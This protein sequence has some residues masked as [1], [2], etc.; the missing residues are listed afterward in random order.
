MKNPV[1]L[2]VVL[3]ALALRAYPLHVFYLHPDQELVP[4][5]AIGSLRAGNWRPG[6]LVYPTGLMYTLRAGYEVI[7]EVGH[8]LGYFRD[9]AEFVG[10]WAENA[11]RFQ[12]LGRLW[13]CLLGVITVV[14]V[15]RLSARLFEPRTGLLA[16]LFLAVSFLHVRES[17]YASLDVP[18]T[19]FFTAAL[20]AA[21]LAQERGDLRRATLYGVFVGLA[22]AYRYQA[23]VAAL[24]L[25]VVELLRTPRALGRSALG[26]VAAGVGA[27][28]AFALLSPYT[29]LEPMR[30]YADVAGQAAETY[31]WHLTPSLPLHTLLLAGAGPGMC[32]LAIVGLLA[33]LRRNARASLPILVPGAVYAATLFGAQRLFARYTVLILP[34]LAIFA[35]CGVCALTNLARRPASRFGLGALVLLAVAEPA[36]RSLALDRLLAREDTRLAAARWVA[37]HVPGGEVIGINTTAADYAL[38]PLPGGFGKHAAGY[39]PGTPYRFIFFP[40]QWRTARRLEP[41]YVITTEYPGL[42]MFGLVP[43]ETKILLHARAILLADFVGLREGARAIFD[44]TDANYTPLFGFSWVANPGPNIRIWKLLDEEQRPPSTA[45]P[46]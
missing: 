24:A 40:A 44:P 19:A 3:L 2:A 7:Y 29:L 5:M 16:S 30:A 8:L 14:L 27:L 31:T 39:P 33:A 42:P 17:H 12:L 25:P 35:A 1:A 37:E 10:V 32:A 18:A 9:R 46:R 43:E 45:A 41:R 13:S 34:S 11:F 36:A 20:V 21:R 26:L 6:M 22:A 23:A 15:G 28:A 4:S 38:P